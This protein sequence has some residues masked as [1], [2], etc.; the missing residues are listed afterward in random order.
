MS[1][2]RYLRNVSIDIRRSF[3]IPKWNGRFALM[4]RAENK[5]SLVLF[6]YALYLGVYPTSGTRSRPSG[7]SDTQGALERGSSTH[8][9]AALISSWSWLMNPAWW[10]P[11]EKAVVPCG[12]ELNRNQLN[13]MLMQNGPS[14]TMSYWVLINWVKYIKQ[15]KGQTVKLELCI[16]PFY[17]TVHRA[18]STTPDSTVLVSYKLPSTFSH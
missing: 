8:A 15:R 2:G 9:R 14:T 5:A 6:T 4:V 3:G 18:H 1:Y 10:R 12:S 17:H 7:P 11:Q 16:T 13:G